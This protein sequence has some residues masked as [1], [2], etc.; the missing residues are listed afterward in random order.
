MWNGRIGTDGV[1]RPPAQMQ[2]ISL[3][4]RYRMMPPWLSARSGIQ[5][6]WDH[7]PAS[8]SHQESS[9]N[10]ITRAHT[11]CPKKESHKDGRR[12]CVC[13]NTSVNWLTLQTASVVP[14]NCCKLQFSGH[15]N[16]LRRH[17]LYSKIAELQKT[18]RLFRISLHCWRKW[19]TIGALYVH[20]T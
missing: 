15:S 19:S 16:V 14:E 18:R 20:T 11:T 9:L 10:L 13:R 1:K 17:L 8:N 6:R 2:S 4:A 3:A 5:H 12:P 7:P